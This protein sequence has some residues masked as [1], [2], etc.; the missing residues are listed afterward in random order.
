MFIR[1]LRKF[2]IH[3]LTW[4]ITVLSILLSVAI[5]I[6]IY[7]LA[8]KPPNKLGLSIAVLA[9][10]SIAPIFNYIT[11]SLLL[12]LDQ[13]E[14]KLRELSTLDELTQVFNRR[15]ILELAEHERSR[16]RRLEHPLSIAI[17]DVDFFKKVNDTYGHPG[18]DVVLKEIASKC[19]Q[20]SREIDHFARYGG[21]EFMFILPE[22]DKQTSYRFAERIRH[23]LEQTDITYY[24]KRIPVTVSIGVATLWED[25]SLDNLLLRADQALYKAKDRGKNQTIMA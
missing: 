14:Q 7:A 17:L 1:L 20:H 21:E 13:K 12:R 25:E 10:A 15:H 8:G 4:L 5:T 22:A 18:G 16:A 24:G 9:P 19:K 3:W 11:L 6:T 23:L 2:G